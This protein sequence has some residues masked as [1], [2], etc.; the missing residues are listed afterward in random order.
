MAD[1]LIGEIRRSSVIMSFAP[2]SV[3]DMRDGGAPVSV[4]SAGLE[5]WDREAPLRGNLKYQKI[6]ERRLCRKLGK[7]HFRL[8]PVL[9]EGATYPPGTD[10]PDRSA[11]TGVRFPDWLQCPLCGTIRPSAR[12]ASEPGRAYRFCPG[13]TD[14]QPGGRKIFVVPVR[15]VMACTK[16]H[17]DEFP[18]DFWVRH[19]EGCTNRH[20]RLKLASEG[21][22]L[23]GL[24]VSCPSCG[25]R[26]SLDGIFRKGALPGFH[27][28]GRRPWLPSDDERCGCT[29]ED[30]RYRVVQRGASNLYYPLL[31]SALDIPPWTGKLE[32][33]LGDFW[34]SLADIP[35]FGD[36]VRFIRSSATLGRVTKREGILPEDLARHFDRMRHRLGQT[37]PEEIR[38]DEYCLFTS[39]LMQRDDE[40]EI[41]AEQVPGSVSSL[42]LRITRVARLREV[43]VVR[44]FTRII[45]PLDPDGA[46]VAPLSAV[47]LDWFPAMEVRGEGIFFQFAP[48]RLREWENLET[49]RKRCR[50]AGE[51]WAAEW[52]QR[53]PGRALPFPAS[54]RLLL[55]HTFAHALI[56]QLTLECG[57][58]SASLRERLYVDEPS[59]DSGGMAGVLIYT[60]APD[61]DGTL[62]GLQRRAATDLAGPTIAGA[63]RSMRWCSSDP[64]CVSGEMAAPESHSVASCHC[65]TMVPETSCELHNRFLDR[66]LIAGTDASPELGYFRELHEA[67]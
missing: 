51:S 1:N 49:V 25:A 15:F 21:P 32:Q 42:L 38:L 14:R 4:V 26:R 46:E 60:S 44:G 55:V 43:R 37:D 10:V 19:K 13:C 57:Y 22:G 28:R 23:A 33:I 29:S 12:W 61:S 36:R 62:G 59:G 54:P 24:V 56:R 45:P 11:L 63:V 41:H 7:K 35:D 30:G 8:P 39:G 2:G 65:C 48:D 3:I 67:E 17:L 31:E 6:V 66:A 40:F 9:Q 52:K 5:E 27:C 58:P 53:N 20:D 34:D 64:L 18:W 16:G 50:G 47:D